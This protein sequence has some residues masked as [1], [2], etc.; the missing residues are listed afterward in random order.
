MTTNLAPRDW[1]ILLLGVG[2][3]RGLDPIRI[4][5]GLFL[6][7]QEGALRDTERYLFRPYDYGPFSSAIYADLDALV[8]EGIVVREAVPGY[9][10]SK[11]RLTPEGLA[12]AHSLARRLS[13]RQ[14]ASLR[15]L[16]EL[17]ADVLTL[18]FTTLLR[19]VYERY[20]NY[21][22]NSVFGR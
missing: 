21:A 3:A 14:H 20:P 10:W 4:Q 9:T 16:A 7:A 18:S 1:L 19:F 17:K 13:R 6:L 5:K 15:V 11:F 8:E 12:D 2:D 22:K